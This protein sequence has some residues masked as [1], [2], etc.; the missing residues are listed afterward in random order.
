MNEEPPPIELLPGTKGEK[1]S[2]R[3]RKLDQIG[4]AREK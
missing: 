2:E 4:I 3:R 1:K